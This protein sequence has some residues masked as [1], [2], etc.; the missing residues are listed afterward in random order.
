MTRTAGAMTVLLLGSV[1]A[2]SAVAQHA[3]YPPLS[4]YLMTEE[5]ELALARTAAPRNITDRATM[6]VMTKTGFRVAHEGSNGFVCMV[7]RGWSAPTYT[8][9][10]FRDLVYDATVRAPICFDPEASRMVAPYYELRA[11]LALEGKT[12]DQIAEGIQVAYAKGSLPAR[13]SVSVAYM[14]SAAQH[15]GPG[16]G[17]F[18][19]HLMV[20]APHY[21]NEMLGNHDFGQ[22]APF[23]SDDGGTPFAVIVI[24]VE[25]SLA[26]ALK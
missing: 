19:P 9:T 20:F 12:P 3:A 8:P 17:H 15:L 7:M 25:T 24:P 2:G 14:W 18:R 6:K 21:T 11:K 10:N 13:G 23:V 4:A 26:I 22:A 16:V 5:A 1:T